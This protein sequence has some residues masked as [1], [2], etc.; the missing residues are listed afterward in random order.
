V[1]EL[2]R[3]TPAPG[4]AAI[5]LG[6]ALAALA[7]PALVIWGGRDPFI[8]AKYA[9]RQRE[10]FAVQSV[11]VLRESGHWPFQDDPERVRSAL[12]GF[13]RTR[14]GGAAPVS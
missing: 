7:I 6:R 8:S 11:E 3:A 12:L 9:E 4:E 10:F 5:E 14:L 13:L 1:L 2:Y